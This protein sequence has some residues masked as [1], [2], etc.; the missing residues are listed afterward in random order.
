MPWTE[1]PT[2]RPGRPRKYAGRFDR[3]RIG[4]L[5]VVELPDEGRRL[6]HAQLYYK[7]FK[8]LLRVVFVLDVDDDPAKVAKPTTL[9]STDPEMEPKR[10]YRIYRD[11]FQIEF[12][13]RDAKQ[14]L[15]L[16][17]CQARTADRHHFHLNAVLAALAWTRLELRHAAQEAL[18]RFRWPTSSSEISWK[19]CCKG[20]WRRSGRTGPCGNARGPASPPGSG[21]NRA[22]AT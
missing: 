2:G 10:I 19:W 7:P 18:D 1:P 4:D 13:F 20:F 15:G 9:F 22:Q 17:A 8:K 21:P 3:A 16:A 14:H 12:N 6:Y 5:P 11:R